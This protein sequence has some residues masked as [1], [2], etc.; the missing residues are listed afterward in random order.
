[1]D[2]KEAIRALDRRTTI[3]GD[4][5]TWEQIEEALDLAI[6]ALRAWKSPAKLDRIRWMGC[7]WCREFGTMPIRGF[8][9]HG[10]TSTTAHFCPK[11]GK[12]L[13]E[14]A[15]TELERRIEGNDGTT[16]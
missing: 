5:F 9:V 15:W 7:G 4:G 8:T 12:P 11:C 13:T 2:K 14:E 6:A 10:C 3:P 1:M 16:D